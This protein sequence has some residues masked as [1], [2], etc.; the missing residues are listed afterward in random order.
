MDDQKEVDSKE[1]LNRMD[2]VEKQVKD[3]QEKITE[4]NGQITRIKNQTS[5]RD[6]EIISDVV[7]NSLQSID[8]IIDFLKRKY[9]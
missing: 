3:Y 8:E 7:E 1:L 5:K 9:K 4:L 6:M 2:E